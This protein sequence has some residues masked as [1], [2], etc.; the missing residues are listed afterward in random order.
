METPDSSDWRLQ[1]QER[2]LTGAKLTFR[3]YRRYPKN[4]DWDHDHCEFCGA[5]FMVEEAP[6]VLHEGYCTLDEYRWICSTCFADF[7]ARFSW[8]VIEAHSRGDA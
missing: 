8:E 1:D 4:P 6:D 2:Y 5:K 3:A 7:R